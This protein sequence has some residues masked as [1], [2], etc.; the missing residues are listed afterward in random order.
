MWWVIVSCEC[1]LWKSKIEITVFCCFCTVLGFV[2]VFC[3]DV[4]VVGTHI[5]ILSFASAAQHNIVIVCI[6]IETL[7]QTNWIELRNERQEADEEPGEI[8]N[9][10]SFPS[11]WSFMLCTYPVRCRPSLSTDNWS[12]AAQKS[13]LW[14]RIWYFTTTTDIQS[15]VRVKERYFGRNVR[16]VF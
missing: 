15:R 14:R 10:N 13:Y 4:N 12:H 5:P 3:I 6:A 2:A 9:C 1:G 8:L 7:V 11:R 16:R